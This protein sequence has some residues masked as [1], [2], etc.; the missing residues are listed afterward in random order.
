MDTN[1]KRKNILNLLDTEFFDCSSNTSLSNSSDSFD[2]SSPQITTDR[3]SSNSTSSSSSSRSSSNVSDSISDMM[4]FSRTLLT[5][6]SY[7][8]SWENSNS[9]LLINNL[10]S[11]CNIKN[12]L[13]PPQTP[14]PKLPKQQW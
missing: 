6:N 12:D 2:F 14:A 8:K 3:S 9:C 7:E 1:L 5:A 11:K 10:M 4:K 13:V